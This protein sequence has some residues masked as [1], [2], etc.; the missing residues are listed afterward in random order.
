MQVGFDRARISERKP[1]KRPAP[2]SEPFLSL[3]YL[4]SLSEQ[5]RLFRAASFLSRFQYLAE[6]AGYFVY[7]CLLLVRKIIKNCVVRFSKS[8]T[9]RVANHPLIN[10][11]PLR[12]R[13]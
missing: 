4:K 2:A 5:P 10:I 7:L 9:I 11:N 12:Q 13:R 1:R 6:T 3:C 8:R